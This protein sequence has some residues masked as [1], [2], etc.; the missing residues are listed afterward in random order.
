M[1]TI[2]RISGDN[3]MNIVGSSTSD[4]HVIKRIDQDGQQGS[5]HQDGGDNVIHIV[6]VAGSEPQHI[7]QISQ[8]GGGTPGTDN[9]E[10][11]YNKPSIESVTLIGDKTFEEL[12]LQHISNME[13]RII[14]T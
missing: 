4:Q 5:I 10:R 2:K 12:G 6:S 11:L 3:T 9:Y 8:G 1:N 13:I 7:K 14:I